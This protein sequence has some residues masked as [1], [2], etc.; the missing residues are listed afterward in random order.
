MEIKPE[1]L[2]NEEYYT[3]SQMASVTHRSDQSVYKLINRGNCIRKMKSLRIAG[4]ILI[5]ASELTKYPFTPVGIHSGS[6]VYH[7]NTEGVIIE[8]V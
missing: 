5:P 2:G 6:K 4:R 1:K 7:Y 8:P 3:V